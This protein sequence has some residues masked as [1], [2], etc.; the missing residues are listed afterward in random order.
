MI[1]ALRILPPLAIARLGSSPDPLDNYNVVVSDDDPL[2]FRTLEPARTLVVDRKSG[3]IRREVTPKAV[4][5]KDAKKRVK[6][7]APF[8]EVWADVDGTLVP[9]TTSLLRKE[10]V[11]VEDVEWRA[12]V[13][14]QKAWRR[15]GDPDD[16]IDAEVDWFNDHAP[17]RL[18]GRC[19]NFLKGKTL[20]FGDVQFIRP[21]DK[22]P[23]VRLRFTPGKGSVYGSTGVRNVKDDVK[24]VVYD[25]NRGRWDAHTDASLDP[26]QI[27]TNPGYI[28]ANLREVSRG[29][30]DDEC[31]GIVEVRIEKLNLSAFA[32]IGAGPPD[33]APDSFPVRTI[34]DELEQILLGP[35]VKQKDVS[36]EWTEEII[37]RAFETVRLQNTVEL[38]GNPEDAN[39]MASH[40]ERNGRALE[41]I[42]ARAIVDS[43]A[44][45]ALHQSIFAALRSGTAPWF[46]QV[47]REW[48]EVGD[49]TND[50]RRKMP[51]MMRGSDGLHLA[52]T[53]R[54]FN[55]VQG[56]GNSRAT[57]K[58]ASAVVFSTPMPEGEESE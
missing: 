49:L 5:F 12:H 46:T 3:A 11:R 53:R 15:T 16:R 56:S 23:E 19:K 18:L 57:A 52:L 28:Y 26:W 47:L 38:N 21:N 8:L 17:H 4:R 48:D 7:V 22:F 44:L 14:N 39:S 34:A 6:P 9:L 42:M 36:P 2:G 35:D 27:M 24:D 45:R 13:G 55:A 29:Y 31:D 41:P 30:L 20:P 54:Q 50:G 33:Y 37:R 43:I 25:K 58:D 10:K 1:R 40:D 51:A 32:R